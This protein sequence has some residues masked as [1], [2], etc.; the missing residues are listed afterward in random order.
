MWTLGVV[1]AA[2]GVAHR[3]DSGA[4]AGPAWVRDLADLRADTRAG[5][6]GCNGLA[7]AAAGG[8]WQRG[9]PGADAWLYAW[10]RPG[11]GAGRGTEHGGGRER[12]VCGGGAA[13]RSSSSATSAVGT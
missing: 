7:V 13:R 4:G 12:A 2:S 6:V 10:R 3:H 11:A 1:C 9:A 5:R 8:A